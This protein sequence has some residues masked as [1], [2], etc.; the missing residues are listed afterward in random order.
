MFKTLPVL[1]FILALVF[2]PCLLGVSYARSERSRATSMQEHMD[3]MKNKSPKK[4]QRMVDNAKNGVSDCI[5]CHVKNDKKK[6]HFRFVVP[7]D[8]VHTG[9]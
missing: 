6:S 4:Y 7:Q 9:E 3:K 2:T 5:S 1:F 8:P